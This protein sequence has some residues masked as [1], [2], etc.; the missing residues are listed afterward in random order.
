MLFKYSKGANN[1]LERF[2]RFY[3]YLILA[4]SSTNYFRGVFNNTV[5]A[6]ALVGYEMIIAISCCP[7]LSSHIQCEFVE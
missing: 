6:L 2:Y 7:Y 1:S 5:I 3:F 4:R